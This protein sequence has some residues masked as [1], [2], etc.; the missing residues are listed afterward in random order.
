MDNAWLGGVC[1]PPQLLQRCEEIDRLL[2]RLYRQFLGDSAGIALIAVGGYGRRELYPSSDVDL[3]LLCDAALDPS[4]APRVSAFFAS[5]WTFSMEPAHSVRTLAEAEHDAGQDAQFFTSLLDARTLCGDTALLRRLQ[6]RL[7]TIEAMA[8]LPFLVI[9]RD[10]LR[11]RY[12]RYADTAYNLEPNLKEGPGGLRDW[13]CLR[14]ICQRAFAVDDLHGLAA[15]GLLEPGELERMGEGLARL[16]QMRCLLHQLAGRKEERL[17][18]DFQPRL[19]SALGIAPSKAAPNAV[20]TMMHA[21][22]RAVHQVSAIS[23]RVI[24]RAGLRL[25]E[26]RPPAERIDDELAVVGDTVDLHADAATD[27]ALR[28][29]KK[30]PALALKAASYIAELRG[31]KRFGHQLERFMERAV[32]ALPSRS[33]HNKAL[34]Q[35]FLELLKIP[36]GIALALRALTRTGVLAKMIP[37]FARV[38]FRMQYDLFHVYT[39]DEHTLRLIDR[40]ET[41]RHKD[42]P[43]LR[44]AR[45][46]FM[47]LRQPEL[48]FL[49]GIFHDIAKGQGGDHSELGAGEVQAFAKQAGM[50]ANE[51]SLVAWLVAQHLSMSTTS[52]KKDIADPE[53]VRDFARLVGDRE[54]LDYLFLLTCADIY[55]TNPKLWN[56]WKA[57]LLSDLYTETRF[58]LRRGFEQPVN[59]AERARTTRAQATELLRGEGVLLKQLEV[60]W[61]RMPEESFLRYRPLEI[62]WQTQALLAHA[63]SERPLVAVRPIGGAGFELFVHAPDRDGLFASLVVLFDRLG[64]NIYGAR[65]ASRDQQTFDTFA[66][67]DSH[68]VTDVSPR[69]RAI[70]IQ[71]A[72]ELALSASVLKP[73]LARR[74]PSRVQRQFH[75]APVIEIEPIDDADETQLTLVCADRPGILSRVA[76]AIRDIKLQVRSAKIATFG[77]RVED[78]FRIATHDDRA[79]DAAQSALLRAALIQRLADLEEL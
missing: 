69:D 55:G 6:K 19:A 24:E 36:Q 31:P 65:I 10:E 43:E 17:V 56:G 40:L 51:S 1:A 64:L 4:V 27:L 25:G 23:E 26:Q 60:V 52:Q 76:M 68:V 79:L 12:R 7:P 18:F 72:L 22:F 20:E 15:M 46:C 32:H 38:S 2:E 45:D 37:A 59:P 50:R 48:L 66:V 77:E 35:Q 61:Q 16:M 5:L 13:H 62:R 29:L 70:E 78:F 75:F 42:L 54:R 21:Y 34:Y 30:A 9:K 33:W 41:L 44:R 39:V 3:L 11:Q 67:Q 57:R 53:V 28:P 58:W 63:D 73:K 74:A 47:R 49:A 14:W 8:P 71:M